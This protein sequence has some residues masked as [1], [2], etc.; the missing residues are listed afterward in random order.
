MQFQHIHLHLDGRI[1]NIVLNRPQ[2]HNAFDDE[3]IAEF[4]T[5][6][7]ALKNS[8]TLRLLILSATGKSF[9]AGADLNWM[10]KMVHYNFEENLVDAKHLAN[11]L[12][13]L[14][15]FPTPTLAVVQGNAFG[16]GVGLVAA[17][18]MAIASDHV[19]FCL[20]ETRIGLIPAVISPYVI[21]AIGVRAAQRYYLTAESF[22]AD[23]A[24]KLGLIH[25]MTTAENLKIVQEEFTQH[26]MGNSPYA[27][28]EAKA[29][30]RATSRHAISE[31]MINDTVERIAKIRS[32]PEGQEGL[33]AFL[34]K[35]NPYWLND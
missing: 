5:A 21:N 8:K 28:S 32:S 15:I 24:M 29:L 20:S 10:Q 13:E 27:L 4:H 33:L 11:L 25:E 31:Q 26:I 16:G 1:A 12:H 34:Q 35:R 9:S 7:N 3:M 18:D 2:I 30:L 17:C 22:S 6:L 19:N 14:Y 23:K